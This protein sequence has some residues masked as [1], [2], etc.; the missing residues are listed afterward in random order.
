MQDIIR[1]LTYWDAYCQ[2]NQT[3]DF[4]R[5]GHWLDRQLDTEKHQPKEY[6]ASP[7]ALMGFLFG[8]LISYSEVWTRLAFRNLPLTGFTDFGILKFIEENDQPTKKTIANHSVAEDSTIFESIKRLIKQGLIL[9][10]TDPN[11]KRVRRVRLS[12]TGK[13]I[14]KSAT[15]SVLNL[16]QLLAGDLTSEEKTL[17]I[18]ILRKLN[19]FHHD[20]YQHTSKEQIASAYQL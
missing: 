7:E 16:S 19:R 20:L 9:E 11:D 6:G 8:S 15:Q 17:M 3:A 2:S 12:D 1:L 14:V 13:E 10:A 18:G 4:K 5:F